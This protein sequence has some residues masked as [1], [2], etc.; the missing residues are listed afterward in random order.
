MEIGVGPENLA[1]LLSRKISVPDFQRNYAWG[2][3]EIDPFI[4]DIVAAT[5]YP[6]AEHFFGPLVILNSGSDRLLV[7]GQ[8]RIT[9]AVMSIAILRDYVWSEMPDSEAQYNHGGMFMDLRGLLHSLLYDPANPTEP[10][11]ESN[12][13]LSQIFRKGVL[14]HPRSD[15]RITL[16][17]NGA[18]LT[19]DENRVSKELRAAFIRIKTQLFTWLETGETAGE[20]PEIK[21]WDSIRNRVLQL[22]AVLTNG[23]GIHSMVLTNE[24]DAF[25]LFETLN[26]RGLK[27]SPADLLKTLIMREVQIHEGRDLL[28]AVLADWDRTN[29]N[30]GEY[31]F[32][33]FLRHHLLTV[34]TGPIQMRKVFAL[35]K[36]EVS[37]PGGKARRELTAL[38]ASS[39]NYKTLLEVSPFARMNSFSETHR[40]LLLAAFNANLE[41]VDKQLVSRAAE[42]LAFR[43]IVCGSNAQVLENFY[44]TLSKKVHEVRETEGKKKFLDAIYD[45]A[46]GDLEFKNSLKALDSEIMQ[47]F[48]LRRVEMAIHGQNAWDDNYTLEHLA[49]QSPADTAADWNTHVPTIKVDE[50]EVGYDEQIAFL[51]NL[52]LLERGLNSQIQNFSWQIKVSGQ[53]DQVGYGGLT[54]SGTALKNSLVSIPQWN[55]KLISERTDYLV[56]SALKLFSKDWVKQGDSMR[57][58]PWVPESSSN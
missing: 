34:K 52:T 5:Q 41:L 44:Q 31:P 50:V 2:Q 15:H 30:V 8:Q 55:G 18:N 56:E 25:I 53:S 54:A 14:E 38:K 29:E 11:F 49:P 39:A 28:P 22:R 27:L 43:W 7:D 6:V 26:E 47:K 46:P 1:A 9:T 36:E 10:K 21:D 48:L 40:V 3:N 19:Q 57:I 23:F 35:F 24:S 13:Q 58:Q 51:G 45:F 16:T 37:G 33:K 20:R 32:S 17:R 42:Y 4:Q 12:Y